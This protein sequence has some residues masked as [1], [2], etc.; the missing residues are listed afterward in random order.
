MR[1]LEDEFV[2]VD[3]RC[4]LFAHFAP[5]RVGVTFRRIDLPARKFP[6]AGEMDAVRAPGDEKRIVFLDDRGDDDCRRC[7]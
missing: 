2:D 7:Q 4:E 3:I 1:G 6:Q 5:E